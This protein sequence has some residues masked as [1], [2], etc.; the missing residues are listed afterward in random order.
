MHG[1]CGWVGAAGAAMP[2]H[3]QA[4]SAD[5]SLADSVGDCALAQ[6]E[7]VLFARQGA[8]SAALTGRPRF[9]DAELAARAQQQG[10]AAVLLQE[11]LRH[12]ERVV[13]ALFGSF[14]LVILDSEKNRALLAVDRF[15][16]ERLF[17]APYRDGLIFAT[18]AD[19]LTR[20]PALPRKLSPQGLFHYVYFHCLP[21]PNSAYEHI[22]KLKLGEMV[23]VGD[24]RI[25]AQ[26][27]QTVRF[28]DNG[29]ADEAALA[30][31]LRARLE[32]AVRRDC[33]DDKAVGAFLS[34][35][36]DSSTVAGY[37]AKV[38]PGDRA[39]QTFTM[40][41]EAKGYDESGF[42][43]TVAHHFG[44]EHHEYYV[45]PED[46]L[47]GVPQAAAYYDE[48]FGNSSAV[49]A[50]YCAKLA[51]EKGVSVMLAGDGGDE[52]FAG[53]TRYAKQG[54]FEHYHRLPAGLRRHG[55]EAPLTWIRAEQL[56]LLRKLASYIAQANVPLP[57][58]LQS[59]NF[60]HRIALETVFTPEFLAQVQPEL[61]LQQLRESY[62]QCEADNPVDRMLHLD[63]KFTLADNDLVKVSGMC[64]LAGVE[65]RYPML[66]DELVAFSTRIPA[67]LKL[68]GQ[69]LRYFYKRALGGFL[70]ESTIT[71]SKHGFGLP[72][73]VWMRTDPRLQALAYDSLASLKGRGFIRAEF[74]DEA[75]KQ[76]REGHAAYYGELV[77]ILMMLELWL[78][79]HPASL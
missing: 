46:V 16:I 57:D 42:A 15:G 21:S 71:K 67:Q 12:G 5:A 61:P 41:F 26:A 73:G 3:L 55:I 74:L 28:I 31:E 60:L 9:S 51:K 65:V 4:M 69:E 72:F 32:T 43:R 39:A 14:A 58:R 36:L 13:G 76:H 50:Y 25:R 10:V 63:W 59:Y 64:Q 19:T 53:N 29:A 68:R 78:Q 49:A 70:P 23:L 7:K 1:F 8:L 62:W 17:Y 52:L 77:W 6:G 47:A 40:G 35:G 37:L 48:P 33:G 54:I 2:E 38:R 18:S 27:Y 24:G 20:H 34:G 30:D 22:S 75:V 66:D 79:S 56:P 45:T 44:T 11:F